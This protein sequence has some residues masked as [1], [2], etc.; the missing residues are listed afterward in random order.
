LLRS[1]EQRQRNSKT[2]GQCRGDYGPF[3]LAVPQ[4]RC[5]GTA[6]RL[7]SSAAR[8][9]GNGVRSQTI[10]YHRSGRSK[11]RLS[12]VCPAPFEVID[13][14]VVTPGRQRGIT[15]GKRV[16]ELRSPVGSSMS[17]KFLVQIAKS[18]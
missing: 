14:R 16:S 17:A 5:R 7:A 8:S 18:L 6:A 2:R 12:E 1:T 3:H 4:N 11:T 10:T 13:P 15:P 9:I